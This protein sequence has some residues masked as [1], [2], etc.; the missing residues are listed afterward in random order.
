M[1]VVMIFSQ[2]DADKLEFLRF[3]AT[4]PGEVGLRAARDLDQLERSLSRS[5]LRDLDRHIAVCA[6]LRQGATTNE[7]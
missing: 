3:A 6:Q 5:E 1:L 4:F 2:A 7:H